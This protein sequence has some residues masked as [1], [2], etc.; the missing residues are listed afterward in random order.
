[1]MLITAA[2]GVSFAFTAYRLSGVNRYLRLA[3]GALLVYQIGFVDGLFT[4]LP[5]WTPR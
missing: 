4:S 1:M 5:T 3:F 2:I